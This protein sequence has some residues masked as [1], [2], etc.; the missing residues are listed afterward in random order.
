MC[1]ICNLGIEKSDLADDFLCEYARSK[2]SMN[3]AAKS[4]LEC[5]KNVS[6]DIH[7]NYDREYK[8]MVKL[9]REWNKIEELRECNK[10]KDKL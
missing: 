7:K 3:K 5:S 10:T 1:I 2:D 8:H 4:L 9:I 6:G